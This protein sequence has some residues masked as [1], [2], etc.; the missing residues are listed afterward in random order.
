MKNKNYRLLVEGDT[1][2]PDDEYQSWVNSDRWIK[3]NDPA[4]GVIS[5]IGKPRSLDIYCSFR[6][7]LSKSILTIGD[8]NIF[9]IETINI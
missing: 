3:I 6:R 5:D 1:I 4:K 7:P 2:E 9:K 8:N